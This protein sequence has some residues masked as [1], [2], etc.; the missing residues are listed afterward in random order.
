MVIG[1]RKPS[2]SYILDDICSTSLLV[3]GCS[4]V[5]GRNCFVGKARVSVEVF[6]RKPNKFT[7]VSV[8]AVPSFLAS[9]CNVWLFEA[10]DLRLNLAWSII[11]RASL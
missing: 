1:F 10:H 9:D 6:H 3:I 11:D 5:V 4:S 2:G 7:V 8:S